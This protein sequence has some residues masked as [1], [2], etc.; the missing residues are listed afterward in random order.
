MALIKKLE[1]SE[2]LRARPHEEV[3]CTYD[4]FQ[5]TNGQSYVQLSTFGSKARKIPGKQSQV[6]QLDKDSARQLV[7]IIRN[8]YPSIV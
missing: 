2:V 5:D 8:A 4:I 6:I 1:R 3:D 7:D